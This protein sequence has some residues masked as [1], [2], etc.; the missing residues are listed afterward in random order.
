MS[1]PPLDA[2]VQANRPHDEGA[3]LRHVPGLP[4]ARVVARADG[5]GR[6]RLLEAVVMRPRR[7]EGRRQGG[8]WILRTADRRDDGL[9]EGLDGKSIREEP[10][11]PLQG[12]DETSLWGEDQDI[13]RLLGRPENRLRSAREPALLEELRDVP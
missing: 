1:N 5:L 10:V 7:V 11:R 3:G 12:A 2:G 6:G 4:E 9:A 8:A 13:D